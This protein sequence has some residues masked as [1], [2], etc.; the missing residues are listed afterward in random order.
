LQASGEL[1]V[2]ILALEWGGESGAVLTPLVAGNVFIVASVQAWRV[3]VHPWIFRA[4]YQWRTCF[5]QKNLF[6]WKKIFF[7]Y[8]TSP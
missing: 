5:Y 6:F 1:N 3:F 7:L 4:A 2:C 8:F